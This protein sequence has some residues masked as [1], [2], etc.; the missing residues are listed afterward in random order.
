MTEWSPPL[1]EIGDIKKKLIQGG[2]GVRVSG[3][4]LASAVANCDGIG[5]IA[6]V[7]LEQSGR[8]SEH[9][10]R[11]SAEALES[12]IYLARSMTKEGGIIGVN[13]MRALTDYEALVI[14]SI[15][16]DA[17]LIISGAGVAR[18]L[19]KY[20]RK[21]SQTKLVPI[22][23]SVKAAL[24][25]CKAWSRYN[26]LPDAII[27]EG[28]KAGGHLG[29]SIDQL[30]DARF[31]EHGLEEIVAGVI[32]AV[33]EMYG[34]GK[35]P[36]IAAGGIFYGG[37]FD[38]YLK[39]GAS[40]VQMATRFVPTHEC[41]ADIK[42]KEEY[43]R[44]KKEDIVVTKSP[45]GMPVRVIRNEFITRAEAGESVPTKCKYHC[46][47]PCDPKK[48]PYCIAEA[49][50]NAREGKEG[51]FACAGSNAYLF[52]ADGRKIISVAETF[53]EINIEYINK[54][55]SS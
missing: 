22:V 27:V 39:L 25:M 7:G 30:N 41:D 5:I 34:A 8:G 13:I 44:C 14:A 52:G 49:L 1:L 48:S 43:L 51:G 20:L 16:A 12:E 15:K 45:V 55:T 24:T 11:S 42:F 38:K 18:D 29:Y 47:L 9:P 19:P 40:G 26:H 46:L 3:A 6:A 53:E 35:I 21:D 36:I 10:F 4:W 33:E 54:K 32:E 50:L 17:N 31:V 23:S 28:P 37:D 2:M